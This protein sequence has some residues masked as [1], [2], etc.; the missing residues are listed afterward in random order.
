MFLAALEYG[1]GSSDGRIY[2]AIYLDVPTRRRL[3]QG[4]LSSGKRAKPCI[5]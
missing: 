3:Q 2:V 1:V 4:E 5:Q